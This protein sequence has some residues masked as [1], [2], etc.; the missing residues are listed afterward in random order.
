MPQAERGPI[1]DLRPP[2]AIVQLT[3]GYMGFL[4][5]QGWTQIRDLPHTDNFV[6]IRLRNEQDLV[7]AHRDQMTD[8]V[9][10]LSG[11]V[12]MHKQELQPDNPT[13]T[14]PLVASE[15]STRTRLSDARGRGR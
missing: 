14:E 11:V 4:V 7:P 5:A 10:E 15:T 1:H 9:Q 6:N 8:D 2:H 3:R 12:L 13:S